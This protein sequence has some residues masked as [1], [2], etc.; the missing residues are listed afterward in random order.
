MPKSWKPKNDNYI[1]SSGI[2]Q[3]DFEK[4]YTL[5]SLLEIQGRN[6]LARSKRI[7]S[8]NFDSVYYYGSGIFSAEIT[9][10]STPKGNDWYFIFQDIMWDTPGWAIQVASRMTSNDSNYLYIR[11]KVNG[12]WGT[13][14]T[15]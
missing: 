5:K 9:S 15:I 6:T 8:T 12:T 4:Y 13:W 10:G 7:E 1:D 3:Y 11:K 2:I 14:R